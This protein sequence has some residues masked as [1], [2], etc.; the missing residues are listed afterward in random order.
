MFYNKSLERI[1]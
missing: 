1:F